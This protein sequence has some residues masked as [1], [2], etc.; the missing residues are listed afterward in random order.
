[1]NQKSI[2]GFFTQLRERK[3]IRVATAMPP[4][5]YHLAIPCRDLEEARGFYVDLLGAS[6][7]RHYPDRI[8]LDFFGM[9]LVCHLAPEQIAAQPTI[10]PRHF[11]LT[12]RE[13]SDF[14]LLLERLRLAGALFFRQPF[15]RFQGMPEEHTAFFLCDP[16]NNLVEFKHY[17]DERKMY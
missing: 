8:T 14:E 15:R 7:A 17:E 10:Y 3:V 11:G 16:S 6:L 1:M 9:Q 5:V 12:F 13:R 4:F 2:K